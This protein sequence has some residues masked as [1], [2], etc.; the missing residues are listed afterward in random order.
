MIQR[1]I[2]SLLCILLLS[3]LAYIPINSIAQ[4]II[5]EDLT[6]IWKGNDQGTYYVR[7]FGHKFGPNI[8]EEFGHDIMWVGLSANDGKTWAN[9]FVGKYNGDKISGTWADVPRGGVAG[10]GTLNLEVWRSGNHLIISKI[11]STGSGFGMNYMEKA[12]CPKLAQ[13]FRACGWDKELNV[14]RLPPGGPPLQPPPN[15]R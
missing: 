14:E 4:D 2:I 10:S 13:S 9:V 8:R 6:G 3:V 15:L 1:Y 12:S 7:H 11:G 5:Y